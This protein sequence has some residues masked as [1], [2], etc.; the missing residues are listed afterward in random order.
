MTTSDYSAIANSHTLQFTT[1]RTKSS[2]SAVSLPVVAWWRI[3]QSLCFRAHVLTGWRLFPQLTH[4]PSPSQSYITTDVQSASL[5][6]NRAPIWGLWPD[7][8]YCQ[9]VA[10]LFVWGALSDERTGLSFTF[11]AGPRHRSH[12][13]VRVPW[14]SWQYFTVSHSRLPSPSSPTTRRATVEVSTLPP[15]VLLITRRHGRHR[16]HRSSVAVSNCCCGKTLFRE[17][18]TQ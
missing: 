18:V 7:F 13:R 1:A 12:F 3:Q 8:Y 2:Q 4:C 16:K 9:T 11:A 6:W 10:D 14:D 15:T 17:A 5:S